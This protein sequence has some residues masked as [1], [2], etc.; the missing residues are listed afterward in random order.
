MNGD[1]LG[2][3]PPQNLPLST[4]SKKDP[5]DILDYVENDDVEQGF[6]ELNTETPSGK[7][8][9]T[10]HPEFSNSLK[11][12]HDKGQEQQILSSFFVPVFMELFYKLQENY[13]EVEDEAQVRE[14]LWKD[15]LFIKLEELDLDIQEPPFE[16]AQK[17][18]EKP[19]QKLADKEFR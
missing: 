5:L 14:V 15:V 11:R 6:Y 17:T 4:E 19:L 7:V 8:R 18:F 12:S 2:V 9:V 16:L 13:S 10:I 1:I 3:A